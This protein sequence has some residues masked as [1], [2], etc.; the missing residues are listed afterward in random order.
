MLVL[1][2]NVITHME[3]SWFP[4]NGVS[5]PISVIQNS[6]RQN[7][8]TLILVTLYLSKRILRSKVAELI[9]ILLLCSKVLQSHA[10]IKTPIW[11][12]ISSLR[13]HI[14]VYLLICGTC[15]PNC[16]VWLFLPLFPFPRGNH[17]KRF[18]T[19]PKHN[20]QRIRGKN[21]EELYYE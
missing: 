6:F 17:F 19:T 18:N 20:P 2:L 15:W 12:G 7:F 21:K 4:T 13:P 16:T 11:G 8:L 3:L 5:I 14:A 1:R 10:L 9:S